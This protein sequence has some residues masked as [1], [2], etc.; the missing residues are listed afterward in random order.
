MGAIV[1]LVNVSDSQISKTILWPTIKCSRAATSK[2]FC[3]MQEV[4]CTEMG[5]IWNLLHVSA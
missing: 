3:R 1:E 5:R 4:F 2:H